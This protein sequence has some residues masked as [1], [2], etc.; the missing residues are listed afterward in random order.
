M[1][2]P[3]FPYGRRYKFSYYRE[4]LKHQINSE[5][6]FKVAPMGPSPIHPDIILVRRKRVDVIGGPIRVRCCTFS[7]DVQLRPKQRK[8]IHLRLPRNVR[9]NPSLDI[10]DAT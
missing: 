1:I 4:I 9:C 5:T 8:W 7:V 3:Y 6:E 10:S 2:S